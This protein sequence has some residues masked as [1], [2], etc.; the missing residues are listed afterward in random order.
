MVFSLIKVRRSDT[1]TLKRVSQL[2]VARTYVRTYSFRVANV[3]NIIYERKLLVIGSLF[4]FWIILLQLSCRNNTGT[5]LRDLIRVFS[6]VGSGYFSRVGSGWFFEGRIR[7]F[8]EGRIPWYIPIIKKLN[9][10]LYRKKKNISSKLGWIR[11]RATF[12]RIRNS[13]CQNKVSNHS[14]N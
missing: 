5:R 6:R 8:F 12:T 3:R 2:Y 9:L 4:L 11:I 10:I 7:M 1:G 14:G 13:Y